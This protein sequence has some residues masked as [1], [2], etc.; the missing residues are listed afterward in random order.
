MTQR[1]ISQ[2][3]N[4]QNQNRMICETMEN[5]TMNYDHDEWRGDGD[6]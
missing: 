6:K 5:V 2:G 1:H 4:R 3:K